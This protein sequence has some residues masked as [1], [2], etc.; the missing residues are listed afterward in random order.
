LIPELEIDG[1]FDAV[2]FQTPILVP[3]VELIF[4]ICTLQFKK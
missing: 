1:R 2:P 4:A 3:P